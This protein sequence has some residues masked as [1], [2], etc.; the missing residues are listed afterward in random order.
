M[1]VMV[2]TYNNDIYSGDILYITGHFGNPL[3]THE[4]YRTA[5]LGE[6]RIKQCPETSR[7][8]DIKASMA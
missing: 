4:L 3:R 6:H 5:S 1:V 7:E 8:L 2:M